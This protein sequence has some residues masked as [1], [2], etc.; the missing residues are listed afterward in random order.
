MLN[1]EKPLER[2]VGGYSNTAIF[3]TVGFVGDSLSSG[4]FE[5]KN[6]NGAFEKRKVTIGIETPEYIEIVEGIN[7]GET[8]RMKNPDFKE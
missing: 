1:N 6:K 2:L 4:E 5:V 3:R 8:V 7:E